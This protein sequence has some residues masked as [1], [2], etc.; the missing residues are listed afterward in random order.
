MRQLRVLFSALVVTAFTLL[1]TGCSGPTSPAAGRRRVAAG[2]RLKLTISAPP[3]P[4]AAVPSR[5]A[6]RPYRVGVS[7][8]TRDDEFYKALEG[9][10]KQQ[11]IMLRV[12][13]TVVSAD[14]DLNKQINQVQ[15]FIAQKMDAIILCPVDSQGIASAVMQANAAHIPVFTADI[16]SKGGRVVCHIA[17]DNVQGGR[18]DADYLAK[19]LNNKGSVAIL[20]LSTVTSVQDRVRGFKDELKKFP[21]IRIVADQD[22]EGA[23]RDNAVPKAV[24]ILTAHP[25]LSAIF[26]INDPVALGA[27]SA[28]QQLNRKNVLI[29]GFDAVPEAQNYIASNSQLKADAMQYPGIIGFT[30]VDAV[31]RSLNGQAVPPTIPI[32]VGLVTASSF[33]RVGRNEV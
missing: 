8:L 30:T 14:K 32:P 4:A 23:T 17:S 11:A 3:V 31:V 13:L 7:L 19:L 24:D 29:V 9:G 33:K 20:D 6:R 2:T 15:N 16:A 27:L 12:K 25:H 10:L 22:V 5:I 28:V 21:G 1:S 18:L 26:G